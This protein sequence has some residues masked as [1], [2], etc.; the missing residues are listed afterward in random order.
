MNINQDINT[1]SDL[2]TT[3]LW[4]P[5]PR[6]T[7]STTDGIIYPIAV[8]RLGESHSQHNP[9]MEIF[10]GKVPKMETGYFYAFL[11][12]SLAATHIHTHTHI[13]MYKTYTE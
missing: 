12:I 13:Y 8:M 5:L 4:L 6:K 9:L 11:T 10:K 3:N 7:L 1:Y 2:T